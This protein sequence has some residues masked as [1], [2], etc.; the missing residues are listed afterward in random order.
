MV[1]ALK[2]EAK[3]HGKKLSLPKPRRKKKKPTEAPVEEK[4]VEEEKP[5]NP[6]DIKA[7]V[8]RKEQANPYSYQATGEDRSEL[9][10]VQ[11]NNEHEE[12]KTEARP[13]ILLGLTLLMFQEKPI[14]APKLAQKPIS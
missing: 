10:S 12:I 11:N 8:G 2:E 4:P 9:K 5:L 6:N 14:E 1:E 13:R 7:E 3:R